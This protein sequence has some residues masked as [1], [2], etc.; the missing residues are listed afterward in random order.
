MVGLPINMVKG[1]RR[2]GMALFS[3]GAPPRRPVF[4]QR[5][6][7]LLGGLIG[8]EECDF[9]LLAFQHIGNQWRDAHVSGVES[10][11]HGLSA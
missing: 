5:A 4:T 9:D 2:K 3:A 6:I 7:A 1:V 11:I 8:G 10:Q